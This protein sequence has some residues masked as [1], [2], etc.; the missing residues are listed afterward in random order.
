MVTAEILQR[1]SAVL[2]RYQCS[3]FVIG[4]CFA[5]HGNL[6]VY[7]LIWS[8][9][10]RWASLHRKLRKNNL[11]R[12]KQKCGMS[13]CVCTGTLSWIT[14]ACRYRKASK[15]LPSSCWSTY[16]QV[17]FACVMKTVLF[18]CS[19]SDLCYWAGVSFVSSI[20]STQITQC[21][22]IDSQCHVYIFD[23]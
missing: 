6:A 21:C 3:N 13:F 2:C 15:L 1:S 22:E 4:H 19:F 18:S 10:N 12:F 9:P 16:N 14:I 8:A 7:T 11:W 23:R 20:C 5:G 17:W